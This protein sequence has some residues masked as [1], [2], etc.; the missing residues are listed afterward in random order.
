LQADE[1]AALLG[2]DIDNLCALLR[3]AKYAAAIGARRCRTAGG[4]SLGMLPFV[5]TLSA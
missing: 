3:S 2:V 5:G 1:D 4:Q